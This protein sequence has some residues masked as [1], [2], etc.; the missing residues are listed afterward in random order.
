MAH[1][2]RHLS[3]ERAEARTQN[4]IRLVIREL[5]ER[6]ITDQVTVAR[7]V[8]SPCMWGHSARPRPGEVEISDDSDRE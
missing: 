2:Q 3:G 5:G 4:T 8:V 7:P 6:Q 1:G